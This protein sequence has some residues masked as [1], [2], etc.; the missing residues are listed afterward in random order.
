LCASL[1]KQKPKGSVLKKKKKKKK[2]NFDPC[3]FAQ[4]E[5]IR[6]AISGEA[7]PT[8]VITVVEGWEDEEVAPFVAPRNMIH[9]VGDADEYWDADSE[10]ERFVTAN[11]AF[12]TSVRGESAKQKGQLTLELFERMVDR[13][14][15]MVGRGEV[16]LEDDE[17]EQHHYGFGAMDDDRAGASGAGGDEHVPTSTRRR[18]KRAADRRSGGSL[19][20]V[21]TALSDLAPRHIVQAVF[22]YWRCKRARLGRPL[23]RIYWPPVAW[24]DTNPYLTFRAR[25][26]TPIARRRKLR[27]DRNTQHVMQKLRGQ[28]QAAASLA[29]LVLEREKKKRQLFEA[30]IG[31]LDQQM[32]YFRLPKVVRDDHEELVRRKFP[33]RIVEDVVAEAV[34]FRTVFPDPND[35]PTVV[36]PVVAVAPPP[37]AADLDYG[38]NCRWLAFAQ[39][40]ALEGECEGDTV[41][42]PRVSRAGQVVLD[43]VSRD[44]VL[45]LM[46]KANLCA[47]VHGP[48]PHRHWQRRPSDMMMRLQRSLGAVQELGIVNGGIGVRGG[49][50][51]GEQGENGDDEDDEFDVGSGRLVEVVDD[52]GVAYG[53]ELSCDEDFEERQYDEFLKRMGWECIAENE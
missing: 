18:S 25:L 34:R 23:Y 19:D 53:S 46:D 11:N 22:A 37:V 45:Q 7:I 36:A 52:D 24:D 20:A 40:V 29:A 10:D 6:S 47:H 2:K 32:D 48:H 44:D 51:L 8:P 28:M 33:R 43:P 9:F 30:Q 39:R 42:V 1:H 27:E 13:L 31:L 4:E 26:D 50:V 14:E 15:H 16:T 21:T 49:T 35:A 41:V 17:N 12:M 3:R 5:H 38:V